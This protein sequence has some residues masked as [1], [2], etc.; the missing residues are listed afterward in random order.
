VRYDVAIIGAGTAGAAAALCCARRGL[1]TVCVERR[2]LDRAGARWV[3]GVPRWCFAEAGLDAPAAEELRDAGEPFHLVAGWGPARVSVEAHD[4]LGCDMRLLV[5]R[6]QRLA[7]EAG[8]ELRE[9]EPVRALEGDALVTQRGRIRARVIVDA[10]GLSGARV[11][12]PSPLVRRDLCAAAQQVRRVR[13]AGAARG[14]FEAHGVAPG[15][16][17]CFSGVSGGFSIVNVRLDADGVTLLTGG[18][19]ADGHASGSQL[20]ASF[21]AR[22]AWIGERLFGGARAIPLGRPHVPLATERVALLGDAACQVFGAHGSGVGAGLVAAKLL[23]D[24]LAESGDP[25]VY[26]AAWM[27]RWGGLFAVSDLLRRFAQRLEPRDVEHLIGGGLLAAASVRAGLE[28]RMPPLPAPTPARLRA[29][30]GAPHLARRLALLAGR[31]VL[32]RALYARFPRAAGAQ[33]RWSR[34]EARA[35]GGQS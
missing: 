16:T 2:A 11:G 20:L 34:F 9:Q 27:R 23:A 17:L 22:H 25:R 21:A 18:I 1:R 5:A 32:A 4:V 3:N 30:A 6:L 15:H 35:L 12:A 33:A 29:L 24:T 14:F 31:V 13:D 19:P 26:A 7:R 28:Q 8:A 10:S